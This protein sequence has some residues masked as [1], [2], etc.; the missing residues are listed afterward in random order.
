MDKLPQRIEVLNLLPEEIKK[1]LS[2]DHI[3]D[4]TRLKNTIIAYFG[5]LVNK[6]KC[7][8]TLSPT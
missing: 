8:H 7:N 3:I 6:R 5:L 2:K 1:P 4:L